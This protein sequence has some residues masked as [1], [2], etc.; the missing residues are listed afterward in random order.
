[1]S[2]GLEQ[3][4]VTP[5]QAGEEVFTEVRGEVEGVKPGVELQQ[6]Y[7]LRVSAVAAVHRG[8]LARSRPLD[9]GQG[10]PAVPAQR[11][12]RRKYEN[13]VSTLTPTGP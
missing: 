2:I 1:M 3:R 13:R 9:G 12:A 7:T 10:G 4:V 5:G 6:G 8:L 11:K